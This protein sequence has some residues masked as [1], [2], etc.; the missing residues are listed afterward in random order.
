[1]IK[2][3]DRSST[4]LT[5]SEFYEN[6]EQSKYNFDVPYQRKSGI[7]SDDMKSF[8]I[9]SI[10]KNYPMPPVFLRPNV[11]SRTGKTRYDIIDGKQ[12]LETIIGFIKG[13]IPLTDY[14]GEDKIFTDNE[15][16]IAK[17]ISGRSFLD[18][19]LNNKFEEF[20]KQ[21]WT[22][23]III[24]YLYSDD[25]ILI[26]N[27]F[28]RLNRNGVQLSKQELRNAKYRNSKL[29]Y[30]IKHLA[31]DEYW[32]ARFI[33]LKNE[34]MEDEEFISE[35]FFL[36]AENNLFE[37]SQ[38]ELDRLYEKYSLNSEADINAVLYKFYDIT[39]FIKFLDI[40]LKKLSWT[41]HLYGLFSFAW[42]CI[43]NNINAVDVKDHLINLYTEYFGKKSADYPPTLS[44]YKASCSSRTR[45]KDQREKRLNAIK[46]F[47][48]V[49]IN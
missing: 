23:S 12:R 24:D 32:S 11:D 36:V 26:A 15:G 40:D 39:Q 22:Y 27:V 6:Y 7:W 2:L 44:E 13:D 46:T 3:F 8:L 1:M 42:F 29:L 38:D 21:F 25:E 19:K 10:M 47:C 31:V 20:V 5:I 35:L 9:D 30:A 16:D 17:D 41:T 45:S 48:G 14:F 49:S 43:N 18:I 37:S 4:K 34:R 33:K 28:D